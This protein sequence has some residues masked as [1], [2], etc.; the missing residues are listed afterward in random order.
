LLDAIEFAPLAVEL[1]NFRE[2]GDFGNFTRQAMEMTEYGKHGILY[3]LL[4]GLW[5]LRPRS[6]PETLSTPENA[7]ARNAWLLEKHLQFIVVMLAAR[8]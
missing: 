1:S 2:N 8:G 6:Q 3:R 4:A 5:R 7:A